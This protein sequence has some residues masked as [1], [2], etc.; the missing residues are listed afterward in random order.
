MTIRSQVVPLWGATNLKFTRILR[1][2][3]LRARSRAAG[4]TSAKPARPPDIAGATA[5]GPMTAATAPSASPRLHFDAAMLS[6]VGA[7]RSLNE[8]VVLYA[9]APENGAAAKRGTLA[10]VADGMGGHAAGEVASALAAE[11]VRR[12]FYEVEGSIAEVFASAFAAANHAIL[13]WAEKHPECSGMGTTCTALALT[14]NEAW[15]AHIGDSRAYLLREGS[16]TQLS[17]DQTLVAGLVREGKL[18]K[19]E[20]QHSPI[21]NVIV[22]ALGMGPHIGP[23]I[24]DQPLAL[25]KDDVIVLCS[26]GLS[27]AV[28]DEAIGDIA[29]RLPPG[30]ACEALIAAALAAGGHDNI[31]VGVLRASVEAEQTAGS[32]RT[33]RP[34]RVP[35]PDGQTRRFDVPDRGGHDG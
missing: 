13:D 25:L 9:T 18:T 16:L 33:T 35:A 26:D 28:S 21:S 34:M 5:S 7:V 20:A 32:G 1:Q 24:W 6:D 27:G 31:S 19:E 2:V 8:D 29:G 4:A 30:E 10:L 14:D 3:R 12:V 22:Q 15:L 11:V 17:D 23:L